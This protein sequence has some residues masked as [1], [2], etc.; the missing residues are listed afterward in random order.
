M[1]AARSRAYPDEEICGAILRGEDYPID[2][3]A[4]DRAR[5]FRMDSKQQMYVWERWK[6]EGDLIIYHSHPTGGVFPSPDDKW[7]IGRSPDITFLIYGVRCDEFAAYRWNGFAIVTIQIKREEVSTQ[8]D[9]RG[10][11]TAGPT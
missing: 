10:N 9:Q 8:Q 6:R 7:V 2:N 11:V 4:K 5:R 3:V 1:V